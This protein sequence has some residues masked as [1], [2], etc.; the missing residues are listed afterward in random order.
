MQMAFYIITFTCSNYLMNSFILITD[1]K[2]I[3]K[4]KNTKNCKMKNKNARQRKNSEDF[5]EI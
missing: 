5:N 1:I 3:I 2:N 4:I